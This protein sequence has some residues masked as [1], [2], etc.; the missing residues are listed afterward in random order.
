MLAPRCAE[1]Q[2]LVLQLAFGR[3]VS[4]QCLTLSVTAQCV[5]EEFSLHQVTRTAVLIN[6]LITSHLDCC[7]SLLRG[8][9]RKSL[10]KLQLVQNSPWW[11][12]NSGPAATSLAPYRIDF[13]ILLLT[14]K[15]PHNLAPSRWTDPYSHILPHSPILFCHPA[16]CPIC[17]PNQTF[18]LLTLSPLLNLAWKHTYSEWHTLYQTNHITALLPIL[19]PLY[20]TI[21][22]P[23]AQ[24]CLTRPGW[25]PVWWGLRSMNSVPS[26]WHNV[27]ASSYLFTYLS[28][29]ALNCLLLWKAPLNKKGIITCEAV[30]VLTHQPTCSRCSR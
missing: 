5:D 8:P 4:A 13:R 11:T 28:S 18:A 29:F 15:I 7:N 6:T 24:P 22:T 27:I 3:A 30:P 21:L 26:S 25:L 1:F 2:P 9:P 20:C 12:H 16:L 17:Q 23:E 10:Y 19:I 14:F